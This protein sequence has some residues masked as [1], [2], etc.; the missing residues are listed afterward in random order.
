MYPTE[1]IK[2]KNKCLKNK[3]SKKGLKINLRKI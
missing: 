2:Y 1:T 3:N